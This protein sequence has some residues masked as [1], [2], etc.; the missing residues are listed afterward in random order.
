[1]KNNPRGLLG[2]TNINVASEYLLPETTFN[3]RS[4][5]NA[6]ARFAAENQG[7]TLSALQLVAG[8]NCLED[9]FE[10]SYYNGSGIADLSIYRDSGKNIIFRLYDDSNTGTNNNAIGLFSH[11]SPPN[12]MFTIGD[13]NR[14]A[15]VSLRRNESE[16]YAPTKTDKYGKLF[17]KPKNSTFQSD[18]LF[19]IDGSG[20][21][22][23]LCANKFD[24]NDARAVYTDS[25]FN[26]FVG[27]LSPGKRDS[28]SC[29]SNTSLGYKSLNAIT[30]GSFN[31]S[32][33]CNSATGISTGTRN[34]IIGNNC[35]GSL[36]TGGENIFIG[37]SI[38]SSILGNTSGN[39]VIGT[40]SLGSTLTSSDNLLIGKNDSLVL[41]QGKL[42]PLQR[43]KSLS[44]PSGGILYINDNA[45]RDSLSFAANKIEVINRSGS[46]YPDNTLTF[47]FTG[48]TSGNLLSL[49][50]ANGP[51]ANN[52]NYATSS[53]SF[54]R[55]DGDL[56][57]R[58]STRFSD[59][60]SLSSSSFL[61]DI[62]KLYS[63]LNTVSGI[64]QSAVDTFASSFSNLF[65]EGVVVNA[66]P[67]PTS[68][69]SFTSG[70]MNIKNAQWSTTGS[71]YLIN[72]DTTMVIHQNA[73]VIAMRMNGSYRPIWISSEDTTC[74]CCP[75]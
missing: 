46:A 40:N 33:G 10:V 54:V 32:L 52:E 64:A 25:S 41:L 47:T 7:N 3:I 75:N 50:Y 45:N 18:S 1:M 15:V 37:N 19:M 29:S 28:L 60:T 13:A 4:S 71:T 58:G 14:N 24:V 72:K 63:N 35:A 2:I 68:P 6:I 11:N 48:A 55:L 49:N 43:D 30:T 38:A 27:M 20:N 5:N 8:N 39:I 74:S 53:S 57:L 42:G 26:T 12:A 59:G 23:D 73:Y 69:T 22:L 36:T 56:R 61:A 21:I 65:I 51:M 62:V 66:I 34:I 31:V 67:A 9:G 16:L 70:I 17:V 44:M